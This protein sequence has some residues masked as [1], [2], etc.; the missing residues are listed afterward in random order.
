MPQHINYYEG[1][2]EEELLAERRILQDRMS[3]GRAIEVGAAGVRTVVEY[4]RKDEVTYKRLCYALYLANSDAYPNPY[5]DTIKSTRV[6]YS[7]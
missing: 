2:T 4:S 5:A 6:A 1:W 7:L 3:G